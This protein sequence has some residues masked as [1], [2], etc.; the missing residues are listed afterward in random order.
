M[1]VYKLII[2]YLSGDSTFLP[3]TPRVV[4]DPLASPDVCSQ[5]NMTSDSVFRELLGQKRQ[6]L[7]SKIQSQVF[8]HN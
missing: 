2:P 3:T 8:I 6:N 1:F 4:H 5:D 7:R